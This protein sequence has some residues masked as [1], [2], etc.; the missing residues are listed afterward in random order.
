MNIYVERYLIQNRLRVILLYNEHIFPSLLKNLTPFVLVFL[1][2][3]VFVVLPLIYS[4]IKQRAYLSMSSKRL[5]SFVLG[6]QGKIVF[7][8]AANST[9]WKMSSSLSSLTRISLGKALSHFCLSF[10]DKRQHREYI[11]FTDSAEQ[12][13]VAHITNPILLYIYFKSNKN[14]L[15]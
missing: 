2:K 1:R 5:T 8:G 7:S 10:S 11:F 3:F 6:F 14:P 13:F 12:G 4:W 15:Y 9:G